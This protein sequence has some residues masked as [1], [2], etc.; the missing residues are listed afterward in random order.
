MNKYLS[1]LNA[2]TALALG[3]SVLVS[4]VTLAFKFNYNYDLS[5]ISIAIIFPLVF[6]IRSAFR[7]REKALEFLSRFKAG[8]ITVSNSFE[9]NEDIDDVHKLEIQNTI[10]TINSSMIDYLGPRVCTREKLHEE[11]NKVF[12]FLKELVRLRVAEGAL[13]AHRR[14]HRF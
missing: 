12:L 13:V 1:I 2:R 8:L 10:K 3:I 5:L 9:R 14:H 6:T 4:Y 11:I 7:R